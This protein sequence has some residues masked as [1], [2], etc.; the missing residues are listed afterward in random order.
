M[1]TFEQKLADFENFILATL[2]SELASEDLACLARL[3]ADLGAPW[4]F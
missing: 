2:A 4:G 1:A 3:P